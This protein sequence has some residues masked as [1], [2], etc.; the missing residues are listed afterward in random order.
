MT[1]NNLLVKIAELHNLYFFT[2]LFFVTFLCYANTLGNG[3]FY[4]DE[5]FIYNNVYVQNFAID[6]YFTENVIAGT[7]KV[8]NYYRPILLLGY[9]MEYKLF[10][11]LPFIYHLDSLLLHGLAGVFLFLLLKKLFRNNFIAIVTSTLFIIHPIQTEAVSYVSG[12]GDALSA[13]FL[14]LSLLFYLERK[15]LTYFLS[16]ISLIFALLSKETAL[17]APGLF[18]L[19]TFFQRK[20]LGKIKKDLPFLFVVFFITGAYFFLRLTTLNFQNT[21]NFYGGENIY[22]KS[23]I[24]RLLTFLSILPIYIGLLFFPKTLFIDRDVPVITGFNPIIIIT[25]LT[26][27]CC[28]FFSIKFYKKYPVFLFSLLWFFITFIPASGILP[29]NGVMYEHFLYIPSI[30]IFLTFSYICFLILQ[31]IT[32]Q[33]FFVFS[34]LFLGTCFLFLTLRT[35]VRNNDWHDP[36]TF[37]NQV[38][39]NNPNGARIH[40]NLAMAYAENQENKKAIIEYKKAIALN[41][42]YPQTHYNLANVYVSLNRLSDAEIEYK[43][44]TEIDPGF[45]RAYIALYKLYKQAGEKREIEKMLMLIQKHANENNGYKQLLQYLKTL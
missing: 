28:T 18:L 7:G 24:V 36:I 4:D 32:K 13:V 3:L 42:S 14:F 21:L 17:I 39:Q 9:G 22:T 33:V 25:I 34:I 5:D 8:S 12:R 44:A 15:P 30:G 1:A 38:I 37:Y 23:I 20:S 40:N 10:G 27:A 43:K 29:I 45:Q 6:K 31:K 11:P 16:A 2:F 26:I 35:I 41:D 19:I